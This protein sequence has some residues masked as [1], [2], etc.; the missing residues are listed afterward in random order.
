MG[1][2]GFMNVINP[3]D[4]VPANA[5][6][7][8]LSSYA[9]VSVA[10]SSQR[11]VGII[12]G[13][14]FGSLIVMA[15]A[16]QQ[17]EY[18]VIYALCMFSLISLFFSI[19]LHTQEHSYAAFLACAYT[20]SSIIPPGGF[21]APHTF[22]PPPRPPP[23]PHGGPPPPP[24]HF[25]KIHSAQATT[26]LAGIT[27]SVVGCAVMVAI[28]SA[29]APKASHKARRCL[30]ACFSQAEACAGATFSSADLSCD[31]LLKELEEMR[32]L[33]PY[34][35]A[36]PRLWRKP[37]RTDLASALEHSLTVL[38]AHFSAIKW[39]QGLTH[40][41]RESSHGA[42][43]TPSEASATL[44]AELLEPLFSRLRDEVPARLRSL[45]S[46]GDSVMHGNSTVAEQRAVQQELRSTLYSAHVIG[47]TK[48][49][50]DHVASSMWA[51]RTSEAMRATV[52]GIQR[53]FSRSG[54]TPT[55]FPTLESPSLPLPGSVSSRS[56][57]FEVS[58]AS[59]PLQFED[60]LDDLRRQAGQGDQ[61]LEDAGSCLELVIY[62]VKE[63][64]LELHKM[65]VT[66][67]DV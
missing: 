50:L 40:R 3:Y 51:R 23:G 64:L 42:A 7:F 61:P 46:F 43:P 39:L 4:S 62:L 30:Q 28:D 25:D 36:E 20:C 33:I 22:E 35:A 17:W 11:I 31:S 15:F 9:G 16:F 29:F 13:K 54:T 18:A 44:P 19:Y 66:L 56:L 5:I 52:G 53:R 60:V 6:C 48:E 1:W 55:N 45:Q 38:V 21:M 63:V 26:L 57:Q 34:A 67:L 27:D 47:A 58:S 65:Q 49:A 41:H 10:T 24:P 32:R 2:V 12:T 59:L 37:F 14:V 8:I